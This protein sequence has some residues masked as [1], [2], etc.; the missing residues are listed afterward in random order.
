[1]KHNA[2]HRAQRTIKLFVRNPKMKWPCKFFGKGHVTIDQA[3]PSLNLESINMNGKT[4]AFA[5]N[6]LNDET[7]VEVVSIKK[8]DPFEKVRASQVIADLVARSKQ[9]VFSKVMT[10]TPA[11]AEALLER[12]EANRPVSESNI[13]KYANDIAAG[14]WQMNGE[15]IILSVCGKLNDGQNRCLAVIKSKGSIET[16]MTFGLPRDTRY[17]LDQGIIRTAG[18]FLAMNGVESAKHVA[19]LAGWI[20]QYQQHGFLSTSGEQRPTK[21]QI[22]MLVNENEGIQKH[23]VSGGSKVAAPSILSFCH[24]AISMRAPPTKVEA[25][26]ERLITGHSLEAKNPIL[27]ARNRLMEMKGN[28]DPN[29]RAEIIF[30]AWN[31]HRTG[32]NG[33]QVLGE[34]PR[35]ER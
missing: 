14:L 32:R 12:N 5:S 6:D 4:H 13:V 20:W 30:R 15:P 28:R 3:Q 7:L 29:T 33:F 23:L 17:S 8:K 10:I 24:W 1:M 35:L 25:F 9:G 22:Q 19:A 26:F 27:I 16:N 34:L 31:N 2:P 11:I 18:H 21:S